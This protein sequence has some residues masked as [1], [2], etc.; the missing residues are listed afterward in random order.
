I[1]CWTADPCGAIAPDGEVGT[2]AYFERLLDARTQYAPWLASA[3][4]YSKTKGKRVLDVG[5]GQGID[6]AHFAL[7]GA[8][9]V[10]IDLTPRHVELTRAHLR[11]EEHTSEL[12]S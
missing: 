12:Q 2:R 8:R 1:D 5:S 6:L 9:A 10:G 3:L 11:S 4:G 7:A